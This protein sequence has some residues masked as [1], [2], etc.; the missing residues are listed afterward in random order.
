MGVTGCASHEFACRSGECV[1]DYFVCDGRRECSDGSD[2]ESCAPSTTARPQ[3]VSCAF[4]QFACHSR[5]QC[6]PQ[7]QHC[8]GTPQCLD[9]S[10]ELNCGEFAPPRETLRLRFSY[11]A[12]GEP[13]ATVRNWCI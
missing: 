6:V 5:D 12:G 7:S 10:D 3:P 2:E 9:F 11:C 1:P 13:E 8:D 4:G